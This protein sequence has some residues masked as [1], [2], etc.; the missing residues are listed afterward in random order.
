M[1][2]IYDVTYKLHSV[3]GA[4]FLATG[5]VMAKNQ[6]QACN[7]FQQWLYN[8]DDDAPVEQ[9]IKRHQS[10]WG[11]GIS[12]DECV[13]VPYPSFMEL[14]SDEIIVQ[15][16]RAGAKPCLLRDYAGDNSVYLEFRTGVWEREARH[17]LSI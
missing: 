12:Y 3:S 4:V 2:S 7:I 14:S 16:M 13:A 8:V 10:I 17:G 1:L 5:F 9:F 11:D 6:L 15:D